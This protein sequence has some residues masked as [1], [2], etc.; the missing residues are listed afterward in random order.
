MANLT[1]TCGACGKQLTVPDRYLGRNLKCPHCGAGFRLEAPAPPPEPVRPAPAAP[2][3]PFAAP[4]PRSV[5]PP[6]EEP[7]FTAEP[8]VRFVVKR[9][10]VLSAAKV[11]AAI[12]GLLGFAFGV[13]FAVS[14]L[15]V[16]KKMLAPAILSLGK[17]A[18][19]LLSIVAVPGSCAIAGLVVGAAVAALYNATVKLFGA[20]QVDL[21]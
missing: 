15:F 4:A 1:H 5:P 6:P 7:Q 14:I 2:P 3:E 13:V 18:A 12:H 20:L 21:E 16:P 9:I 11:S 10:D 17:G 19:A 8:G